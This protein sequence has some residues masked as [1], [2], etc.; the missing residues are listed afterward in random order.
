MT[1]PITVTFDAKKVKGVNGKAHRKEGKCHFESF[2]IIDPERLWERS[3]GIFE[4]PAAI[5]LRLYGT[6]SRNYACIWIAKEPWGWASGS[7]WAGGCG[8]HRPSAAAEEAINNAGF[9]I[10]QNI[11]GVGDEAVIETLFAIAKLI[12]VKKPILHKAHP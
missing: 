6:G 5:D 2:S 12:G 8:Y 4:A 3:A 1:K 7:G 11:G 10:S 9:S